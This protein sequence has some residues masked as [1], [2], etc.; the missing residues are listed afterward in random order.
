MHYRLSIAFKVHTV[1][2][3]TLVTVVQVLLYQLIRTLN[4]NNYYKYITLLPIL[5]THNLLSKCK[6]NFGLFNFLL[7]CITHLHK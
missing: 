5:L 7:E 2:V 3:I 4:N 6:Y 1:V